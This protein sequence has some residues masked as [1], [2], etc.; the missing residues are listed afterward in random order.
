MSFDEIE[1]EHPKGLSALR[2]SMRPRGGLCGAGGGS[3]AVRLALA[4]DHAIYR[5]VLCMRRLKGFRVTPELVSSC[6]YQGLAACFPLRYQFHYSLFPVSLTLSIP[7]R[8][9][10][11]LLI[12]I[13]AGNFLL[14]SQD[15]GFGALFFRRQRRT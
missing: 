8:T 3:F 1:E 14:E 2:E 11:Y 7:L 15:A 4:L 12:N 5:S 9:L 13:L 6:E 10:E